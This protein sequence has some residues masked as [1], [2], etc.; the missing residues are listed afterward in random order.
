MRES[1]E[2]VPLEHKGGGEMIPGIVYY[3]QEVINVGHFIKNNK[4]HHTG[5]NAIQETSQRK[6]KVNG[7]N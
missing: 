1:R 6:Q 4:I 5:V 3:Q 2:M 7:K